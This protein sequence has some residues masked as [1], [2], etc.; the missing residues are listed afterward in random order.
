MGQGGA[1][2]T[3]ALLGDKMDSSQPISNYYRINLS[4]RWKNCEG[5]ISA[6]KG[7]ANEYIKKNSGRNMNLMCDH[8][9][10]VVRL[11]DQTD[12]TLRRFGTHLSTET[13]K[14][15]LF[16]AMYAD[17]VASIQNIQTYF[18]STAIPS[19]VYMVMVYFQ[20]LA[21]INWL[22]NVNPLMFSVKSISTRNDAPLKYE[23]FVLGETDQH[24]FTFLDTEMVNLGISRPAS[25]KPRILKSK[26]CEYV[27]TLNKL[28]RN[29]MSKT[30]ILIWIKI[31]SK[32]QMQ[33]THACTKSHELN[34]LSLE[35]AQIVERLKNSFTNIQ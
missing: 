16:D 27:Q 13:I 17:T 15:P 32:L 34:L 19:R 29:I 26:M 8:I 28:S 6:I 14:A 35:C 2:V 18:P 1:V 21:Y 12:V 9:K 20:Q 23:S 5:Q 11:G 3:S 33:A 22:Y 30:V 10:N 25:T 31:F 24:K 4:L 7:E